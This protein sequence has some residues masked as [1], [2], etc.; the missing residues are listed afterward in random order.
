MTVAVT[1]I[2]MHTL[3]IIFNTL[4]SFPDNIFPKYC[5]EYSAVI[6]EVV[7]DHLTGTDRIWRQ[8]GLQNMQEQLAE[9]QV[10]FIYVES[11]GV[12]LTL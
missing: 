2:L 12:Q 3:I 4:S 9:D 10:Y 5:P 7:L 6:F 1:V 11:N 8:S